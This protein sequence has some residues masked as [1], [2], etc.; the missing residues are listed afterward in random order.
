M[1]D[2]RSLLT[3]LPSRE[4][5]ALY[6]NAVGTSRKEVSGLL[7]MIFEEKDP[8]AWRAAWILDGSD[9]LHQGLVGD[10][11][12][13]IIRKLP[14]LESAGALRS[15]LRMLCRY[16]IPEEEQGLL[17]DLCFSY[18][19]SELYPVAVKVHAMQ[20]IYHHTLL[21]PEL[22]TELKTV[23]EDQMENNSVGFK[24]RGRRIIQQLEKL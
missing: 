12:T 11:I 6:I 4:E 9:E 10:R 23:I 16:E 21:Y 18:L 13:G 8:I 2:I 1:M 3:N 17:I 14:D 24:S 7:V 19:M 5:R 22:K 20:I 15:L